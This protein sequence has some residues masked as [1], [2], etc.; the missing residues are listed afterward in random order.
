MK[1]KKN[2]FK[3]MLSL[4]V[5]GLLMSGCNTKKDSDK[6]V[7]DEK[8]KISIGCMPL[9]KEAVEA[10]AEIMKKDG[11]E[12]E[13]KVFDGNNLPAEALS[14]NEIDCLLLNH[15]PWIGT[16]NKQHNT[17]LTM[18]EGFSY[19]SELGIYSSK[20]SSIDEIPENGIVIIS[21]DPT[22]IDRSLT[23]LEEA[24]LIKLGEKKGEF[25][26]VLDI[27]ENSKNI[28]FKEV[29]TTSTAGSYK[30]ADASVTFTSVMKNAGIDAKSYI[31]EDGKSK[32]FP[33]GFV[34]NKG[35]ENSKWANALVEYAQ[36]EEYKE[37]FDKIFQGAYVILGN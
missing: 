24:E 17:E 12:L 30:D 19:A 29:E 8:E 4:V 25:Y 13:V 35:N 14:S 10:L 31:M 27:V 15:L 36:R 7:S 9:N 11:Y 3:I 22:N 33:V 20:H 23:L 37:V 21:N 18:V 26:N 6:S 1:I 34:V 16:F 5:L 32:D 28:E 2:I